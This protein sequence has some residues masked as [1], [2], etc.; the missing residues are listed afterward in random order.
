MSHK[1][2]IKAVYRL[3]RNSLR[4]KTGITLMELLISMSL[5]LTALGLGFGLFSYGTSTYI[6]G[7]AKSILQKDVRHAANV[8]TQQLRY[9]NK[10]EF[11]STYPEGGDGLYHYIFYDEQS[12]KITE[13]TPT[14]S[15]KYIT[16]STIKNLSFTAEY[17]PI[18]G[19]GV[20]KMLLHFSIDS[21]LN[22]QSYQLSS[23]VLLMNINTNVSQLPDSST[24]GIRFQLP[25]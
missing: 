12:R 11:V 21:H 8:I 6:R 2:K 25:Q 14:G 1:N 10:I 22:D 20:S 5:L 16:E 19:E 7:E 4:S 3:H 23:S 17:K 13:Y 15:I 18:Y 9:A 24:R